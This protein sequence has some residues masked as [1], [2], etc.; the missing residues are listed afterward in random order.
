MINILTLLFI[1]WLGGSIVHVLTKNR[2]SKGVKVLHK[3]RQLADL[4]RSYD[5]MSSPN[6]QIKQ[7][8][9][10]LCAEILEDLKKL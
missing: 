9:V 4:V 8:I 1:A 2:V 6:V 7:C 3:I 5:R 10:N